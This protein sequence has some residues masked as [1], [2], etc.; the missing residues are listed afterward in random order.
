ME[1]ELYLIAIQKLND[2]FIAAI[3]LKNKYIEKLIKDKIT[4]QENLEKDKTKETEK[5][6][7]SIN[8]PVKAAN[9]KIK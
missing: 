1:F 3:E 5:Y 4:L 2:D 9:K 7:S 8:P 6:F